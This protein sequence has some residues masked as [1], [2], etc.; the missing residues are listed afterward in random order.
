MLLS[1]RFITES[2]ELVLLRLIFLSNFSTEV[3]VFAGVVLLPEVFELL[4][5][6]GTLKQAKIKGNKINRRGITASKRL[7]ECQTRTAISMA[8]LYCNSLYTDLKHKVLGA[9]GLE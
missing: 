7:L 8:S 3:L 6:A 9:S 2:L 5:Q 4:P 1:G